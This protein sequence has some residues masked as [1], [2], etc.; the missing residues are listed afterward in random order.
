M[1]RPLDASR[2][3]RGA[4]GT[5]QDL[6]FCVDTIRYVEEHEARAAVPGDGPDVVILSDIDSDYDEDEEEFANSAPPFA[7]G[8]AAGAQAMR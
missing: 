2:K 3:D 7:T 1:F 4:P 6:K 5:C 8:H